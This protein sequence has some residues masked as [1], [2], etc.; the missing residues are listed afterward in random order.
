MAKVPGGLWKNT[1]AV[2]I[3]GANT[4][5]GKTV[6]STLLGAHLNRYG[7]WKV[8]YIK[9]V[10]TGPADEADDRS[11]YLLNISKGVW[12]ND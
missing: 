4:G 1:V 7:R 11:V 2:Q 12:Y 10:S 6:F 5:V 9:P 8:Q 3:Y